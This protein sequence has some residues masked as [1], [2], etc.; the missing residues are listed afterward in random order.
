MLQWPADT[1]KL[2]IQQ[3]L[4]LSTVRLEVV[5]PGGLHVG[6]GVVTRFQVTPEI[7]I[8]AILTN[9]H[10]LADGRK[11]F[12]LFRRRTK[13]SFIID[14]GV[15]VELAPPMATFVEHPSADVDL[16]AIILPPLEKLT[17]LDGTA[18]G[19]IPLPDSL[20]NATSANKLQV[21]EEI[22]MIGYPI[23]LY[24]AAHNLPIV[25]F[26]RLATLYSIDFNGRP[27]FLADIGAFKG[28]S[29]SPVLVLNTG[30]YATDEGLNLGTRIIWLGMVWGGQVLRRGVASA[31]TPIPTAV[32]QLGAADDVPLNIAHCLKAREILVAKD[33][34]ITVLRGM[35]LLPPAH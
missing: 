34:F 21:G 1:T 7:S 31:P 18:P 6:T 4:L 30:A 15:R 5:K 9:R 11:F 28:S 17:L 25:R 2:K 32:D 13:D 35:S 20:F 10:V 22:A 8:N 23:G 29:G 27:E 12:G 3:Q 16:A 14:A 26:G 19:A 33:H 24:D